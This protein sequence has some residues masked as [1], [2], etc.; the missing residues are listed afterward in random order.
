MKASLA[1]VLSLASAAFATGGSD[2][3][4]ANNC[5]RGVT[6]TR[7]GKK[8]ELTSRM[9]DCASFQLTTVT[10][11]TS[12]STTTI[13]IYTDNP[14]APVNPPAVEPQNPVTVI[15]TNVPAYASSCDGRSGYASACSC[16]GITAT[17]TTVATPTAVATA[18]KY[19]DVGCR[20]PGICPFPFIN[21]WACGKGK[22]CTCL[23][24]TDGQKIC[25]EDKACIKAQTCRS[26]S[27]C[28]V[29]EGCVIDH[30][31]AWRGSKICLKY[32]PEKCGN[33]FYPRNIFGGKRQEDDEEPR[34]TIECT[35]FG[36]PDAE[37]VEAQ[38]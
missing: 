22:L 5:A 27:D 26:S 20:T 11:T 19:I 28:G 18:T 15:P 30:C 33:K 8:P 32:A 23:K 31:C 36:C 38:E 14:P 4:N 25:V 29:G 9:E 21:L 34:D 2:G 37:I 24:G 13:T 7:A 10:P 6:G 3:C 1:L 35:A 12:T 16:W 17:A